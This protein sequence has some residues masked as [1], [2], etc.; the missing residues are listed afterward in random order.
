VGKDLAREP[1]LSLGRGPIL[2]EKTNIF[3]IADSKSESIT[4]FRDRSPGYGRKF[5]RRQ[6]SH[7]P[8]AKRSREEKDTNSKRFVPPEDEELYR[9]R[10]SKK[11]DAEEE[12]GKT[13]HLLH[14]S[15]SS[16]HFRCTILLVGSSG[17]LSLSIEETNKLRAKLGLKPLNLPGSGASKT[18]E[19]CN[20]SEFFLVPKKQE[21]L[22]FFSLPKTTTCLEP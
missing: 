5:R 8:V 19:V 16:S 21:K 15:C 1:P 17:A 9:E 13:K 14:S 10:S 18:D 3:L 22:N 4:H 12:I 20:K 6:D 11:P 2:G 7:S